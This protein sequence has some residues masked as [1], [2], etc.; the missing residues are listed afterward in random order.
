MQ[1]TDSHTHIYLNQFD[2][3]RDEMITR[4]NSEQISRFL[5]PNIDLESISSMHELTKKYEGQCFPMMGLHPCSVDENYL[6]TLKK[7]R[8]L[9]DENHYI[10]IGEIGMDLY[11]D[12]S[13]QEQQVEAFKI[14]I[15]W[16]KE[17]DLPIVI[18]AREAFQEIFDVLDEVND[19]QLKGIFHCFTGGAPEA[20]RIMDYG[21]FL[22]GIGGVVT[23]KNSGLDQV[24]KNHVPLDKII[25]ET[26]APYLAPV[27]YRGKRNEPSY[28]SHIV[29]KLVDVYGVT[30]QEIS[31]AT[32]RNIDSIFKFV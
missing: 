26:D 29:E 15:E 13:F 6:E 12:K 11:W 2:D 16:A 14:Q 19:D 7:M 25:L 17:L 31:D 28:I 20:K 9:L 10:A 4:A 30:P 1:F 18:H 32:E 23:F 22:F 3:D 8:T 24:L 27:P 5:L 21:N